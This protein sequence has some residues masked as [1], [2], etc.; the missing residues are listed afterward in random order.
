MEPS[1]SP[2]NCWKFP[3]NY[4]LGYIYQLT[5]FGDLMSCVWK[6]IVK[7][8]HLVSCTNTHHYVIDFVNLEYLE[9]RTELFTKTK[10]FLTCTSDDTFWEV[11]VL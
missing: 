7:S 9:N 11:I 2:P 5:K 1:P 6:D 10:K 8:A 4:A 3:E